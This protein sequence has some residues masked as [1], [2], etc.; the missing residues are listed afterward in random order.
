MS[1]AVSS[2]V[3][4]MPR[5][6][7]V[8][9]EVLLDQVRVLPT[10]YTIITEMDWQESFQ[11]SCGERRF[12]RGP[13]MIRYAAGVLKPVVCVGCRHV[14]GES[15]NDQ[16]LHLGRWVVSGRVEMICPCCRKVRRWQP[17]FDRRK[18]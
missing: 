2:P 18:C 12:V 17:S 13:R 14:F 7:E 11:W 9:I 3:P 4:P 10:Q 16:Q 1:L 15:L 5:W 6:S 8:G